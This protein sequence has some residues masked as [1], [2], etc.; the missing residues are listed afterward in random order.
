MKTK[1]LNGRKYDEKP[2][3]LFWIDGVPTVIIH[4]TYYDNLH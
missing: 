3:G 4:R 2:V 1:P